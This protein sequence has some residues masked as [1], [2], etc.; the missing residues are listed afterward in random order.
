MD[1]QGVTGWR[2]ATYSN[3]GGTGCVE[4][5]RVSGRIAIRDTKNHGAGPVL[6]VPAANWAAF[7]AVLK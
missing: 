3:G 5:G 7:T 2:K 6:A 4:V 1:T